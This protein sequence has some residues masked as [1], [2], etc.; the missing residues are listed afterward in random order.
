MKSWFVAMT[1]LVLSLPSKPVL[2]QEAS[3]LQRRAVVVGANAAAPG[4]RALRYAHNDARNVA[5]ALQQVAGFASD[6]VELLLDPDPAQV[7]RVLDRELAVLAEAP[8]ESLLLFYYSGHADERALYPHGRALSFADLRRRL[9]DL[10][11]SVRVGIIDTCRGGGWTGARGLT[12]T[13]AFEVN[14]PINLSSEGSVLIASSSGL[15]DAHESEELRGGFFTHHWNAALRGAGDRDGDRT[16]TLT[17][18]FDYAKRLTIRDTA[19]RS[20]HPQHPSYRMNLRGRRDLPLARLHT[21]ATVLDVEQERGPLQLVHLDTGVVVLEVPAGQRNVR[22]S[23]QPGRYLVRSGS[24]ST[25]R[26]REIA[27]H[28]RRPMTLSESELAPV[29]DGELR[30]RDRAPRPVTYSTLPAGMT[31]IRF[32]LG[33][34]HGGLLP[35]GG[36]SGASGGFRAQLEASHGLS[37]RWQWLIPTLAF[38]YRGGERGGLEWIPWGGLTRW[39]LGFSAEGGRLVGT[40][41]AGFDLRWW[42]SPSISL[43]AGI[44][45]DSIFNWTFDPAIPSS[46]PKSWDGRATLAYSQTIADAVTLSLGVGYAQYLLYDGGWPVG[47]LERA[48]RFLV[49]AIHS[50][51]FRPHPLIQVHVND[52]ISIDGYA[53]LEYD[54]S[55]QALG[56]T[57]M[58][59]ASFVW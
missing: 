52:V 4:R 33:V 7:L 56:E 48:P 6:E 3:A 1:L 40:L 18:A 51:A 15:E 44:S 38:A 37:D 32:A 53:A 45:V 16:V 22:L 5:R 8:T 58:L 13:E 25:M 27:I 35:G 31:E 43:H 34:H 10:S 55:T 17:E 42:L 47:R 39:G 24:G 28:P 46:W 26:A 11:V 54:F 14:L 59:G 23:L 2:A 36:I 19:L 57:Y 12:E 41:G 49:G 21:T 20:D 29:G 9:D 50:T 30:P